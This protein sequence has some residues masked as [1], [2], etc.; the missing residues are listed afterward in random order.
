MQSEGKM[1]VWVHDCLWW[2][3]VYNRRDLPITGWQILGLEAN[4]M[5]LKQV[6]NGRLKNLSE[7]VNSQT[8]VNFRISVVRQ[9]TTFYIYLMVSLI[10]L[11]AYGL[12]CSGIVHDVSLL[13]I[14]CLP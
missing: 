4:T 5:A 9:T 11:T 6:L 2:Y 1:W 3:A 13:A 8:G 12:T 14:T 10:P 7:Q